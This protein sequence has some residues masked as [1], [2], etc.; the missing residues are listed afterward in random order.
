MNLNATPHIQTGDELDAS[1][2]TPAFPDSPF[3]LVFVSDFSKAMHHDPATTWRWI[4]DGK[5][6]PPKRYGRRSAWPGRYI[7]EWVAS[8]PTGPRPQP[9]CLKPYSQKGQKRISK[10][11][12]AGASAA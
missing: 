2:Q 7:R 9:D 3:D 1:G 10:K 11:A 4:K 12:D 6:D 5:I 8:Q